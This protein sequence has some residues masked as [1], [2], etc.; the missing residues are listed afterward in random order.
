MRSL[1]SWRGTYYLVKKMLD[2]PRF[3]DEVDASFIIGLDNANTFDTWVNFEHLE[4]MARFIVV[5]RFGVKPDSKV[6][7]YLKPPHI[8]LVGGG[9]G[10][11]TTEAVSSTQVREAL[12][13]GREAELETMLDPKVLKHIRLHKLYTDEPRTKPCGNPDCGVSSGICERMTFGSGGFDANGY[14]EYPCRPCAEAHE[15]ETGEEAWPFPELMTDGRVD[16]TGRL[17]H[18]RDD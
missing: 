12:K 8:Y 14:W 5:P 15:N 18:W 6:D 13:A 17:V 10:A 16:K 7:W 1:T 3:R 4:R 11:P 9:R 2:D